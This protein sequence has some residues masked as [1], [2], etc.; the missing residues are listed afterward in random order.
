MQDFL[1]GFYVFVLADEH[2][3]VVWRCRSTLPCLHVVITA[4]EE[5]TRLSLLVLLLTK[6][7]PALSVRVHL[8][9]AA[10]GVI[11]PYV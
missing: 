11:P 9:W 4:C 2:A 3:V 10:G 7:S 6:L 8:L 5:K 1:E